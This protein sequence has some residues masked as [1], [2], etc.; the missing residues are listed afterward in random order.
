MAVIQTRCRIAR[1][2]KHLFQSV[3]QALP[4]K[5]ILIFLL[6]FLQALTFAVI[7]VF[8]RASNE[9]VLLEQAR[10]ILNNTTRDIHL[11]TYEFLESARHIAS[12]S[13][14][15]FSTG[16]IKLDELERS[17]RYFLSQLDHNKE[18]EGIYIGSNEG[19]FIY[20]MREPDEN[21]GKYKV[22]HVPLD[23][24][25]N[26][27][28][29]WWRTAAHEFVSLRE[30]P[31]DKFDPRERPW[32]VK[33]Q[34]KDTFVW[35]SPY[36]FN[37]SQQL[38]IT[39]SVPLRDAG[40]SVIGALG[41]DIKLS[42][43][44]KYLEGGVT[45]L[46]SVFVATTE[47][48]LIASSPVI[49][50]VESTSKAMVNMNHLA[51]PIARKAFKNIR[52][53]FKITRRGGDYVFDSNGEQYIAAYM[54]LEFPDGRQW[55]VG[56]YATKN[57]FLT[58][59][60]DNERKNIITACI[61]LVFS[62]LIGWALTGRAWR[63]VEKLQDQANKDPLTQLYNRHYLNSVSAH[64]LETAKENNEPL[65]VVVID[66]D[67]FKT[68]NDTY[69]HSVGDEII[70]EIAQ[71]LN[72]LLRK[73]DVVIRYGGEEFVL[74]LPA[75]DAI[76]AKAIV[77][78]AKV[79]MKERPYTTQAGPITITFSAGISENSTDFNTYRKVFDAADKALYRAKQ[80]GRDRTA[81][82][83]DF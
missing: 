59:I 48:L 44:V 21:L 5:L 52:Q 47:G 82:S 45:K 22:K 17:E 76:S 66:I 46:G 13:A 60:R 38:G 73:S 16:I 3:R 23:R 67:C 11:H 31:L 70:T 62:M 19:E 27:T 80:G 6:V 8:S 9:S 75:T 39:A 54:P 79:T 10:Q 32:F 51:D 4:T 12:L 25:Q 7:L 43:L 81:I 74:L 64:L 77:D 40:N 18:F 2:D 37:T 65:S 55:V 69:G 72:A 83:D 42:K 68:V 41:V 78:R 29:V 20:V 50:N 35:T 61:I 1:M 26:N 14:E 49:A 34:A 53:T 56:A 28:R 36:I 15:L 30:D 58:K 71:R 57:S 24:K 33:A 63:P